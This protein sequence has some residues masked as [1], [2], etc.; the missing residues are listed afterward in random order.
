MNTPNSNDIRKTPGQQI[1]GK[2]NP[3]KEGMSS[4][5]ETSKPTSVDTAH[6]KRDPAQPDDAGQSRR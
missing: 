4:S 1:P 2:Q 3:P 5:V 6:A